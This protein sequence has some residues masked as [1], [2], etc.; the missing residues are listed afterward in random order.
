MTPPVALPGAL[1]TVRPGV[2]SVPDPTICL[3]GMPERMSRAAHSSG[4]LTGP[5]APEDPWPRGRLTEG[6]LDRRAQYLAI[7]AP[8]TSGPT[9]SHDALASE[10]TV[11]V[12]DCLRG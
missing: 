11:A 5:A 6:F 3:L 10:W 9:V 12:R 4:P 2:R 7:S 1:R 8:D